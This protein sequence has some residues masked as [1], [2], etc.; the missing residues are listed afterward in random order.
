M[1][2]PESP[3]YLLLKGRERQARAALGRLLTRPADS[4]EV[5]TERLEIMTALQA[6]QSLGSATYWDCFK[7]TENKNGLRTWTGIML[8]GVCLFFLFRFWKGLNGPFWR[9]FFPVATIDGYQLYLCV[10]LLH[11]YSFP[12]YWSFFWFL[13]YLSVYY[14]TVSL[15]VQWY[16]KMCV[17]TIP[18]SF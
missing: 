12:T 16:I 1:L 5:E 9:G 18:Q 7:N 3:R 14:G 6:E 10:T 8:Q 15:L 17:F 11:Y 13:E 4:L 2:L